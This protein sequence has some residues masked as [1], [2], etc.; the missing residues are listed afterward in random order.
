MAQETQAPEE[1]PKAK[2]TP[3][4]KATSESA[5]KTSA[6]ATKSS[7]RAQHSTAEKEIHMKR[8]YR[9]SDKGIV[10]GVAAGLGEYFSIDPAIIRLLFVLSTFFGGFG[11]P[12]YLILWLILPDKSGGDAGTEETI[13]K[14]IDQMKERTRSF[15]QSFSANDGKPPRNTLALILIVIGVIFL[16]D[17]LDLIRFEL[18]WPLVIIVIGLAIWMRK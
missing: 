16:M 11:I 7:T 14:N 2:K 6:G 5:E 10:A 1:A 15:A 3:H 8:L 18:F 17:N 4:K 9:S 12:V 13:Q